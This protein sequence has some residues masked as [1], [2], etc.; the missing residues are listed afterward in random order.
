[1]NIGVYLTY[2]RRHSATEGLKIAVQA[3]GGSVLGITDDVCP[4]RVVAFFSIPG[5]DEPDS[6]VKKF[7]RTACTFLESLKLSPQCGP[8]S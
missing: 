3:Y 1:M 5:G 4:E 6:P 7:C 2:D 8:I